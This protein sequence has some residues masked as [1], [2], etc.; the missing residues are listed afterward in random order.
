MVCSGLGLNRRDAIQILIKTK[1]PCRGGAH[2]GHVYVRST[3]YP[4]KRLERYALIASLGRPACTGR[5]Q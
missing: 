2:T 4:F 3:Q 5:V 1:A